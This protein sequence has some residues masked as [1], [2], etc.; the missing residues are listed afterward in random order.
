MR[1]IKSSR[2]HAEIRRRL[3]GLALPPA[4]EA[5]I[6]EELA[7]HLED[8]YARAVASGASEAEAIDQAITGLSDRQLLAE[9]LRSVERRVCPEP[10]V[11]GRAPGRNRIADLWQDLRY[12]ARMFRKNPGFT[13]LAVLS[14]A[15]G[16]GG[17]A[18]MFNILSA[19]LIRPLPYP[20]P[21]RLVQAAN[22]GYYPPGGLVALQQQSR[23]MDVAGFR[24][25]VDLNLTGHGGAWRVTGSVVSGNLFAV[26]GVEAELGRA[27]RAGDDQPGK[28]NLVVL[29]HALWQDR[30]GGDAAVIGRVIT[31]GGVDRQVVGVMPPRFAFPDA[32]ARFWIPLR[33]DPRDE[34]AYWAQDFL[35]VIA[36]LRAGVTL[37]QAQREI[38]WLSRRMI[39]LYPYPMGRDFNAQGTVIPL[40]EFLVANVRTR[41]MVLQC[42]LGLVLLIACTN[43]ANL[44]LARASTRQKEIALRTALGA[45]RGRI[46]RQLLTESVLLALAGGAAGLALA[47]WAASALKLALPAGAAGWSDFSVGW[48]MLLFTGALSV[49]TGLIFGLTP[50]VM[51]LRHDL[52]GAIKTGSQ[53]TMGTAKAHFRSALIVAEVALAVVL[54]V[55]AGLL[56]R[57]LWKLAQVDPGFQPQHILTLRVSPD[58]SLCSQRSRC[59]A[60]YDELLR[61][62]GTIPRVYETAAANT[63]PLSGFVPTI[64]VVVEGHPYTPSE[65]TAPLFWAG[66]VTPDYFRLMHIPILAG[67]GLTPGDGEKSSPVIVVSAA[68]AHRYWPG[69]NPIGKHVRPVF[70]NAWR[71]V[72]GVAADVRQYDLANRAPDHIAGSMY[73]PYSQ[74][75]ASDRHLPA[76]MTLIVSVGAE[77]SEAA[78]RIGKMVSDSN[79]NVPVSDVRT[80]QSLV[81]NSTQQS[82]SLAWLF[83]AFAGVALLLAATGAYGVVSWSAA[84]RTFEIGLRVALGASRRSVF[85][86]ILGQSLRLVIAGLAVG[87]GAS[88]ALTRSLAAFLYATATWDTLT[89]SCVSGVLV[90]VALLAGFFPARRAAAVDPL[91]S[92]RTE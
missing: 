81:D 77:P 82:R 64:P 36:R 89:F 60:L 35:P 2:W 46:V 33:L 58:Q 44:L 73:M 50:A 30:F 16:I 45:S 66:A 13:A 72:V 57:S 5:E 8:D 11:P 39:D 1:Y 37:V 67:R 86:L 14:L 25:G 49:V 87:V 79:P 76:A 26:L 27:L 59:I 12:A 80:M 55:G 20:E 3:A 63:L 15:L 92:L 17:N 51:V 47:A 24:P 22:T 34:T 85:T 68:T 6:I 40:Q 65:R 52:A 28:D 71:T 23:L 41:L 83:T 31:L 29:S 43:V 74:A 7:Q 10:V 88:F 4:R 69:E 32:A 9:G 18:A 53:R 75:V 84:Q 21:D 78:E 42:A 70:E 19:V 62:A 38:Q 48:Q 56:I 54:S 61:R 91:V 90:V